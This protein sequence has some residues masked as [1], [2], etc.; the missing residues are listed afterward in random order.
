MKVFVLK[1]DWGDDLSIT[2]H[3]T[4][5]DAQSTIYEIVRENWT[6]EG[7]DKEC[8]EDH[9]SAID[10][11]FDAHIDSEW[12]D[13]LDYEIPGT[14]QEIPGEEVLLSP[15][16]QDLLCHLMQSVGAKTRDRFLRKHLMTRPGF[17]QLLNEVYRKIKD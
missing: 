3:P 12:H 13:I 10:E 9:A 8:P 17:D 11:Y 5:E 14:G 7:F 1:H 2:V 15:V 6:V 4:L 16:E